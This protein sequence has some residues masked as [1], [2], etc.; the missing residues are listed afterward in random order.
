MSFGERD[1]GLSE[2]AQAFGQLFKGI[3]ASGALE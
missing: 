3:E 1:L 2:Y